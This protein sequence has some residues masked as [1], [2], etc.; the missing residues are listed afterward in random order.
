MQM[1]SLDVYEAPSNGVCGTKVPKF[2]FAICAFALLAACVGGLIAGTMITKKLAEPTPAVLDPIDAFAASV[3]VDN[4]LVTLRA[5]ESIANA[6][7]N[8]GSRSVTLGFGASLA[9]FSHQLEEHAD[10]DVHTETFSMPTF[11]EKMRPKLSLVSQTFNYTFQTRTDVRTM[12]FGGNQTVDLPATEI[13]VAGAYGCNETADFNQKD[14]NGKIILVWYNEDDA[15]DCTAYTKALNAYH[16]GAS[17]ILIANDATRHS[18]S[19]SRLRGRGY[20]VGLYEFVQVPTLAISYT[21]ANMLTGI[22]KAKVSLKA[23]TS[24]DIIQ[25]Q[26]L[27]C[28]TRTGNSNNLLVFG[29]HLDSVDAGPGINDNGSGA[30]T[31]LEIAKM[32]KKMNLKLENQIQF[33]FWGAEEEGLFGSRFFVNNTKFFNPEKYNTIK[34]SLNFDTIASPNGV[35]MVY[36]I[37]LKNEENETFPISA[38]NGSIAING[39]ITSRFHHKNKPYMEIA[40]EGGSDYYSFVQHGIPSGG[41]DSGAADILTVEQAKIF[42][43]MPNA[44]MDPCYHEPCDK[45]DNLGL[46]MLENLADVGAYTIATLGTKQNL[47]A[48]L[49]SGH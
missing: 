31:L 39:V 19:A 30:S 26:N 40:F 16:A 21:T 38:F 28:T 25:T 23:S 27:L 49:A 36:N 17:A 10:C 12:D 41:L 46:A 8:K 24:I 5:L 15:V 34:A 29:A 44:V 37:H 48:F 4:I 13:Y 33:S 1:R 6:P 14:S 35:P 11:S 45:V 42:G 2:W 47:D 32:M 3:T 18:L 22:E 43:G 9:H 20:A 7:G